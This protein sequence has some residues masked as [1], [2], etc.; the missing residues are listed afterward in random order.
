MQHTPP[1][2]GIAYACLAVFYMLGKHALINLL[3]ETVPREKVDLVFE[4]SGPNHPPRVAEDGTKIPHRIT[5]KETKSPNEKA[6]FYKL[7]AAMNAAHGGGATHLVQMLGKL[8]RVEVSHKKSAD[9]KATFANLKGPNG[10]N[11]RGV[12]YQDEDERDQDG[13]R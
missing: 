5:V 13:S 6:N 4:L 1:N 7:F 8:F 12:T 10:Y 2:T 11:V 9:G 3:G